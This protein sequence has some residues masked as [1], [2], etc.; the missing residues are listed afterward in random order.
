MIATPFIVFFVRVW[1]Y[2]EHDVHE[3]HTQDQS[4]GWLLSVQQLHNCTT[5]FLRVAPAMPGS[6]LEPC[7]SWA[8]K[9]NHKEKRESL[10]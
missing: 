6:T 3:G 7:V 2:H 8:T 1:G 9:L 4:R 5:T 10:H